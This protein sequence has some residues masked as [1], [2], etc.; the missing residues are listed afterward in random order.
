MA[1]VIKDDASM[2]KP[3]GMVFMRHFAVDPQRAAQLV[4]WRRPRN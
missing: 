1:R 4:S 3:P 2:M